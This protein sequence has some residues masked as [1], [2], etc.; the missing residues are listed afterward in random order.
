MTDQHYC[1]GC[2][3]V[4]YFIG[5]EKLGEQVNDAVVIDSDRPFAPRLGIWHM[6]AQARP[7][8]RVRCRHTNIAAPRFSAFVALTFNR[9][10]SL[11]AQ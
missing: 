5:I 7:E 6:V 1:Q 11:A 4:R 9:I 3:A 10:K 2:V 8:E